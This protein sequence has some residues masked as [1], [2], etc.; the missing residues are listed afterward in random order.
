VTVPGDQA[1]GHHIVLTHGEPAGRESLARALAPL[2]RIEIAD[3]LPHALELLAL[4]AAECLIVDVPQDRQA[5]GALAR[6][7]AAYPGTKIMVLA[8][9]LPFETARELVRIGV[10]D[11]LSLPVDPDACA[12][13]VRAAL[14]DLDG[15]QGALRGMSI[16]IASGKGGTG[17]T[18]IA[19]HLAAAL[20]AY[21]TAV[22]VD[23]DAPPFGTVAAAAD[24][25]PGSSIAGL[26][27]QRLPVEPRVL[28]RAAVP[29]PAGFCTFS[30][31]TAPAEMAE[32]E[33]AAVSG[34]D[35]L[36]AMDPFVI[37][38]IGR[39]ALAPQRLLI[40]RAT[41]VVAVAT[42]DLL[43]LRNHRQLADLIGSDA[44]GGAR[45][46]P[47]L[48]RC[49]GDESY[50]PEQA[51]AAV[52]RPF[53]AVLPHT[54]ALR[55]CLDRGELMSAEDAEAPWTQTIARLANEIAVRRR[56]EVRSTLSRPAF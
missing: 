3:T 11:V 45:L 26:M 1:A 40:R 7:A 12:A 8:E 2:G 21:G 9:T 19:L 14:A 16:A 4:T 6:L 49:D 46:V 24:L 52:G 42:L 51:A 25:D 32:M 47:V 56:D 22:V 15:G 30:L 10:R 17:C 53:A 35:A 41:V 33:E 18:A 27:R 13:S 50:T 43:A 29:H 28:R 38:D 31:W 5:C 39:P 34:L 55:H 48:N 54:P 37:V 20:A 44:G 36:A 23:A